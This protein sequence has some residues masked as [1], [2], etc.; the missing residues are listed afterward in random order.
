MNAIAAFAVGWYVAV[1]LAGFAL[2]PHMRVV[3]GLPMLFAGIVLFA[4][5]V[6]R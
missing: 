4:W 6:K 1:A 3:V 5:A 2:S